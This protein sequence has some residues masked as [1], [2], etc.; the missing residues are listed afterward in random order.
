MPKALFVVSIYSCHWEM[1]PVVEN[2]SM[3]GNAPPGRRYA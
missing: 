3:I 1:L 2:S